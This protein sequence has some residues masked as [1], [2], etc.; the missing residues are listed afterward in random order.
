V[1]KRGAL[2]GGF[3]ESKNTPRS[4]NISVENDEAAWLEGG[5]VDFGVEVRL[6]ALTLG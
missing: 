4:E 2:Y 5:F 6:G 1:V 3:S